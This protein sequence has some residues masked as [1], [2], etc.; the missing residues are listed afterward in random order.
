MVGPLQSTGVMKR[1]ML[2]TMPDPTDRERKSL[3]QRAWYAAHRVELAG[4][5]RARRQANPESA[6]AAN[7]KWRAANPGRMQAAHRKRMYGLT[8]EEF[9]G[10]LAYQE[11][12]CVGCDQP[13]TGP[14]CID[15][16]HETGDVRGLLCVGCNFHDALGTAWRADWDVE[17]KDAQ[18][19][20]Q[21]T[22]D[23]TARV[24]SIRLEGIL[25]AGLMPDWAASIREPDPFAELD[26][27]ARL[28][29]RHSGPLSGKTAGYPREV[30]SGLRRHPSPAQAVILEG[31]EQPSG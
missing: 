11:G 1:E 24:N 16:D 7:R 28:R 13:F 25:D 5:A 27:A 18:A 8:Q 14:I 22:A 20:K 30:L 9:D 3:N 2:I 21:E 17:W 12:R 6:R 19:R 29:E 26:K 10:L 31:S 4:K 15:H 23:T